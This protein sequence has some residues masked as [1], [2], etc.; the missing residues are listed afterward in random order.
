MSSFS[1]S[2]GQYIELFDTHRRA[3]D[4]HAPEL[5][6]ALRPAAREALERAGRFPRRGDEGYARTDVDEIFAPDYGINIMRVPAPV[7]VA[8]SLRC[9]VPNISTL[10]GVMVGDEFRPTS[11][12]LRNLP[13]GVTMTSLAEAARTMPG[14]LE[15]HLGSLSARGDASAQLNTL[16][17][18]DGVLVHVAAGVRVEKP[19]QLIGIFNA[20]VPSMAARRILVVLEAGASASL[21][22]CDHSQRTDVDYLNCEVVEIFLAAGARLDYCH[23][24]AA[25]ARSA[26]VSSLFAALDA[27]AHLNLNG[28]TLSGGRTR[29]N[30]RVDLNAPGAELEMAGMVIA[31]DSQCGD[32]DT[33]VLHHADHCR[34]TQLFKYILG[35]E[36]RGSFRGLV[37]V[38]HGATFT[39]AQ[40]TNRNLLVS[41]DATMHTEP[42]LEIYCDEVK[43]GHGATTGQL[44]AD[45]LFYMRSRGIPEAE[46]RMM[47]MQAFMAD[48]IDTI[49]IPTLRDRLR[50]LVERRLSGSHDNCTDCSAACSNPQA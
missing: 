3:I 44:D 12:L 17:A 4:G 10:T 22:V 30:Y 26:R 34:S 7:D 33:L 20:G 6:N 41:P 49:S 47:L 14:V 31:G 5:L 28:T 40:Q 45:A 18:Q 13:A 24:E 46:A 21:L 35:D 48:V 23:I 43:C 16:L 9:G 11:T 50:M 32:N 27:D 1:K 29:N 19:L 36:A 42:Q 37:R 8:A 2:L 39:D 38:D 15:S 25:T